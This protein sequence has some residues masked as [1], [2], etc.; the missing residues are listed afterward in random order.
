MNKVFLL[1][2]A[3]VVFGADDFV[4]RHDKSAFAG[5]GLQ[6]SDDDLKYFASKLTFMG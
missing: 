3:Y 4:S 1:P 2:T 5:F 6:F